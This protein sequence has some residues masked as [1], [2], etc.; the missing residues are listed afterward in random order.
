M[1][2]NL[3]SVKASLMWQNSIPFIETLIAKQY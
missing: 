2:L 1:Q 3:N